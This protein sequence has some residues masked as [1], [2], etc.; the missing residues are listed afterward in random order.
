MTRLFQSNSDGVECRVCGATFARP[1][2]LKNKYK[3]CAVCF[4]R[5][6]HDNGK[7]YT[8][9][10]VN[11]WLARQLE[12][13]ILRVK[14]YGI[15][16]KCEAITKQNQNANAGYQCPRHATGF[17][18][19]RP[20][21]KIHLPLDIYK[22]IRSPDSASR[23]SLNHKQGVIFIDEIPDYYKTLKKLVLEIA[24]KDEDFMKLIKEVSNSEA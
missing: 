18:N 8:E 9:E 10:N 12:L 22:P 19:G 23:Q 15:A 13:N 21:C 24:Q 7:D 1:C 14:K 16:S 6:L 3:F 11:K 20:V 2:P 4:K 17:Y 5:M